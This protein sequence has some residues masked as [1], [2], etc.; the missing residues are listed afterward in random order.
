MIAYRPEMCG[1][2]RSCLR[3][4]ADPQNF[5]DVLTVG[6]SAMLQMRTE[7]DPIP[8]QEFSRLIKVIT[9]INLDVVVATGNLC[10]GPYFLLFL[11]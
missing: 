11:E 6:G 4:D 10:L 9:M 2:L 1:G 7:T 8:N 5:S 3:T